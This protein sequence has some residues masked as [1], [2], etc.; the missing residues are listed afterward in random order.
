MS[1]GAV[2]LKVQ[3][4][5]AERA[6]RWRAFGMV[7]P[8]FVFLLIVF[9]APIGSMMLRSVRDVELSD[10]WPQTAAALQGWTLHD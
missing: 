2:G 10:V 1:A 7:A 5:R 8:L 4:A 9:V 6:R 3:L